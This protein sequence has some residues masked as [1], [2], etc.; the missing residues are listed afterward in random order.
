M[1]RRAGK[2]GENGAQLSPGLARGISELTIASHEKSGLE[3]VGKGEREQQG[4]HAM[5]EL[6]YASTAAIPKRFV[7]N[8][9]LQWRWSRPISSAL[10]Q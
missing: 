3:S 2:M 10:Q 5:D 7:T 6:I 4:V 1:A 9:C 8:A